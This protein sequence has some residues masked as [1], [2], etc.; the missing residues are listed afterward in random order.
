MTG[1]GLIVFTVFHVAV[2][3]AAIGSGGTATFGFLKDRNYPHWNGLFL[4]TS[5]IT[6]VTGFL[7]PFH[8]LTPGIVIGVVCLLVLAV[9]AFARR[10]GRFKIYIA[11]VCFAEALNIIVLVAQS[12]EKVPVLHSVAPTGKE[13]VVAGSQLIAAGDAHCSGLV[14]HKTHQDIVSISHSF[15]RITFSCGIQ[16][17]SHPRATK[18]CGAEAEV[19]PMHE[20]GISKA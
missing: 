10:G 11:A 1:F 14:G 5:A 2:S 3:L 15:P 13:P 20:I 12:F 9:A 4:G 18:K 7:F 6:Y 8:G 16:P 19:R 17:A